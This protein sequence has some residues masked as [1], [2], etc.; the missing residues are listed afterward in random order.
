MREGPIDA[1]VAP[2]WESGEGRNRGGEGVRATVGDFISILCREES[3]LREQIWEQAKANF[4]GILNW[5]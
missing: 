1:P 4:R 3:H 2:A 5:L